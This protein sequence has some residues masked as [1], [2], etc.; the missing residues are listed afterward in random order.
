MDHHAAGGTLTYYMTLGKPRAKTDVSIKT[1]GID[2]TF[3]WLVVVE[4]RLSN[5]NGCRHGLVLF[6]N[7]CII[8]CDAVFGSF[9]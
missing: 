5:I 9:S 8:V 6:A 2:S 3:Y 4:N 1:L 7:A